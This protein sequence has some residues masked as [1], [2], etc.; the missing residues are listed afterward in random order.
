MQ[1]MAIP[2]DPMV[3][4][5]GLYALIQGPGGTLGMPYPGWH[6]LGGLDDHPGEHEIS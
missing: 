4:Y 3:P 5:K 2:W 6:P 1:G